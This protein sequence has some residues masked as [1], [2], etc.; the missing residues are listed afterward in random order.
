MVVKRKYWV[1]ALGDK[2][3][4]WEDCKK[5]NFVAIGWDA[6]GNANKFSTP[7]SL[8]RILIDGNIWGNM[9]P[10]RAGAIVSEVWMFGKKMDIND[11]VFVKKGQS[12]IMGVGKVTS[13]LYYDINKLSHESKKNYFGYQNDEAYPNIRD[14]KWFKGYPPEGI[15]ISRQQSWLRT[16]AEVKEDTLEVLLSELEDAGLSIPTKKEPDDFNEEA[17]AYNKVLKKKKSKAEG[18]RHLKLKEYVAHN[19]EC[20]GTSA[21]I[22]GQLEFPFLSGD[23]CDVVFDVSDDKAVV[24]EIKNGERGELVKGIY[25]AI[26]YRALMTAQKGQGKDCDVTAFLVAYNIPDD[27]A[28]FASLF[29]VKCKVITDE[30]MENL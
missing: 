28:E 26:K 12:R 27:I 14:V 19:P 2:S 1:L 6:Y 15:E 8:K 30:M 4:F 22:S 13:G 11:I 17:R 29:D 7:E 23:E 25:Q 21:E 20:I 24:V 16:I 9:T 3:Y 5:N 18:P 10:H